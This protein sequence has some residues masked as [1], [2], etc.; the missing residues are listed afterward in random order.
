MK[1]ARLAFAL[2][3]V[4]VMAGL[5]Q[6]QPGGGGG[7]RGGRGMGG[8]FTP[9]PAYDKLV[10][11][12]IGLSDGDPVTAAVIAKYLKK[13]LPEDAP[14]NAA[15]MVNLNA[16]ITFARVVNAAGGDPLTA[17]SSTKDDWAKGIA[18]MPTRGGGGKGGK[19]G[20]KGGDTP[21]PEKT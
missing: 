3:L 5:A 12:D 21:A 8:M 2:L 17:T 18:A 9:P 11:A 6:A 16:V 4:T 7:G 10:S 1:V 13:N 14:E 15:K 20:K 19:G